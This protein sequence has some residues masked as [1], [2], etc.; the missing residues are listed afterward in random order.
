MRIAAIISLVAA[1]TLGS[2]AAVAP[3]D[4]NAQ[5]L[6]KAKCASC[7]GADGKAD[8]D[9][10]KKA[11]VTSMATKEWQQAHTDEGIKKATK[12]GVKKTHKHGEMDGYDLTPEQLDSLVALIRSFGG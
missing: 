1:F 4:K 6:W 12:E 3:P 2:S 5:R 8:T 7:H 9:Q 10:G 11:G